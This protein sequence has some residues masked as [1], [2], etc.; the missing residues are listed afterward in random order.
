MKYLMM[1]TGSLMISTS[2]I[3]SDITC[4]RGETVIYQGKGTHVWVG[5]NYIDFVTHEGK[6]MHIP[7]QCMVRSDNDKTLG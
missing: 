3:A 7:G 2:C 4:Y 5:Q 1:F 6:R